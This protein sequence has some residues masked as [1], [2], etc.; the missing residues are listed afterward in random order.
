MEGQQMPETR[1][2]LADVLV[3]ND[4]SLADLEVSDVILAGSMFAKLH[5]QPSSNGKS[6]TYAKT[7]AAPV[8]GFRAANGPIANERGQKQRVTV[9]LEIL[10]PTT[11]EDKALADININ[12]A[13]YHMSMLVRENLA[14]AFHTVER[15]F[16]YGTGNDALGFTGMAEAAGYTNSDDDQVVNGGSAAA[17]LQSVWVVRTGENDLSAI[18]NGANGGN[19]IEFGTVFEQLITTYDGNGDPN[20]EQMGYVAP[21]VTW[22]GMQLGSKHSLVRVCNLDPTDTTGENE[23]KI[24][25][26]ISKFPSG[27]VP[28]DIFM[29]REMRLSI[30]EGRQTRATENQ[31]VPL[32]TTIDLVPVAI[33]EGLIDETALTPA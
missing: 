16:I 4:R 13:A 2:T 10:E 20:G 3:Y 33:S 21:C 8:I 17:R 32:A 25:K 7:I 18:Y 6:H 1:S 26:A 30:T 9:D 31:Q 11:S 23:R 27:K 22:L 29:S 28:T 24:R 15:Q 12:G 19:S 5:A 14:S